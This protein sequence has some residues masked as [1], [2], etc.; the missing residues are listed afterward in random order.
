MVMPMLKNRRQQESIALAKFNRNITN[1]WG[2]VVILGNVTLTEL[3]FLKESHS[4]LVVIPGNMTSTQLVFS[5][6]VT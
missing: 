5:R 6:K 2:L 3:V 4:G 1:T